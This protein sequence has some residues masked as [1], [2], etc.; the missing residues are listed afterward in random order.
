MISSELDQHEVSHPVFSDSGNRCAGTYVVLNLRQDEFSRGI[1]H[2]TS[3]VDAV[4]QAGRDR[5]Q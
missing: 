2:L 4:R 5:H 3:L 1:G